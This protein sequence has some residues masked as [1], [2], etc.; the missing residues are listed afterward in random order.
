MVTVVLRYVD[1]MVKGYPILSISK[2]PAPSFFL[3]ST[4]LITSASA[5][6]NGHSL[7]DGY[8][9]FLKLKGFQL[10]FEL[11]LSHLFCKYTKNIYTR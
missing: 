2:S 10:D 6:T 9:S 8:Q 5:I 1:V 3:W 11:D 4:S 7:S